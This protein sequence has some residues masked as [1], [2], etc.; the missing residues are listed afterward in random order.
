LPGKVRGEDL[1]RDV[2]REGVAFV[3]GSSFFAKD[4][5]CNFIR[6]NFSNRPPE[7]IEEGIR[8]IGSTLKRRLG[9]KT[10]RAS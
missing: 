4:A 10:A 7:M 6:L 8:R 1:L 2:L 5:R 9:V 3:P